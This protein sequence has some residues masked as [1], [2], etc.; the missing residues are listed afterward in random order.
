MSYYIG[1]N[2][3]AEQELFWSYQMPSVDS[4]G[5]RYVYVI[6][7]FKTKQGALFMLDHGRN[8]P[9]CVTVEQAERLA[10]LEKKEGLNF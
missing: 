3:E 10:K 6:G 4:H 1:C 2:F 5:G 9:H 8:N 7:P